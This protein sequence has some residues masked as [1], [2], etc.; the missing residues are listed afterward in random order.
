LG[1]STSIDGSAGFP[2]RGLNFMSFPHQTIL[3]PIRLSPIM[4]RCIWFSFLLRNAIPN[5]LR[6]LE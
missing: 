4:L 5:L 1:K 3:V 6:Q 2:A